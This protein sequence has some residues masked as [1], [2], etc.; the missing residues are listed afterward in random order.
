LQRARRGSI[1]LSTACSCH[2]PRN[3][4]PAPKP[5]SSRL[6]DRKITDSGQKPRNQDQERLLDLGFAAEGTVILP[7]GYF[8]MSKYLAFGLNNLGDTADAPRLWAIVGLV[9][10]ISV[11]VHGLTAKPIMHYVDARRRE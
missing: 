11:V 5:T 6:T 8:F 9:V 1:R 7:A 2:R 3:P 4:I 10:T